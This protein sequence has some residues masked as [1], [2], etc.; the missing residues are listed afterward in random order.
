M[1]FSSETE[2]NYLHALMQ[3]LATQHQPHGLILDSRLKEKKG[4][5]KTITVFFFSVWTALD[6]SNAVRKEKYTI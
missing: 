6:A 1:S 2:W 3:V 4:I 5:N